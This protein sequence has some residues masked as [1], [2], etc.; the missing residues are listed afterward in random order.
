MIKLILIMLFSSIFSVVAY[1]QNWPE[2][3]VIITA[4]VAA[5]NNSDVVGR[6]IADELTKRL[7]KNFF[8]E[9][10]SGAGVKIAAISVESTLSDGYRLF[11]T[12]AAYV[13]SQQISDTFRIN[14]DAFIPV[15]FIGDTVFVLVAKAGKYK[16][17]DDMKQQMKESIKPIVMAQT[18]FGGQGHFIIEDFHKSVGFNGFVVPYK[19]TAET[20]ID[21]INGIA[22]ISVQPVSTVAPFIIAGNLDAFAITNT[23]RLSI[24]PNTPTFE[25]HRL[26]EISK[27]PT[28]IA[29]FVRVG[30]PPQIIEKLSNTL[31]AIKS[32]DEFQKKMSQLGVIVT[33]QQSLNVLNQQLLMDAQ[34]YK[35]LSDKLDIKVYDGK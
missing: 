15:S 22:D 5:G 1:S 32:S 3:P 8:I 11:Y 25:E 20:L 33:P 19:R 14:N 28:W 18:G 10:K 17:Y 27:I 35:K 16:S 7:G 9:N 2:R 29:F 30:T 12:T 26:P 24:L 34:T 13:S 6:I 21:I 31:E 23:K 4:S